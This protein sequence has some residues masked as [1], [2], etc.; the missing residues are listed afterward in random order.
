VKN[1]KENCF[2]SSVASL[3]FVSHFLAKA[4]Q[5]GLNDMCIKES[6]DMKW[7]QCYIVCTFSVQAIYFV[8][9]SDE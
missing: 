4:I 9:I 8:T 3:T 1:T 2:F 5:I 6:K 7:P